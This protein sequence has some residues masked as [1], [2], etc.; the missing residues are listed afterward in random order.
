MKKNWFYC[1]RRQETYNITILYDIWA[2]FWNWHTRGKTRVQRAA[3]QFHHDF[4][5]RQCYTWNPCKDKCKNPKWSISLLLFPQHSLSSRSL[6]F[7]HL[8]PLSPIFLSIF[9]N[10]KEWETS[11]DRCEKMLMRLSIHSCTAGSI[12]PAN[13]EQGLSG[14]TVPIRPAFWTSKQVHT[15]HFVTVDIFSQPTPIIST[16]EWLRES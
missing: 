12:R 5:Y 14:S 16:H 9:S 6:I 3:S 4:C 10:I 15:Q 11:E 2:T 1:H 7:C 13:V 8:S